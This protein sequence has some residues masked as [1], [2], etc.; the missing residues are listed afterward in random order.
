MP[1]LF[2]TIGATSLTAILLSST[3]TAYPSSHRPTFDWANTKHLITF[4][5]SYTYV[6]G[7]S[8]LQNYSFI[9]DAQHFSFTPPQL[10]ANRIVQNSTATAEGGP[11][12][13]E[14][15]TGC[16]L[17]PGLTD[18]QSCDKQLWDFAFAGADV[19]VRPETP[20]HHNYTVSFVQQVE[21]FVA[22]G[23]P[24]L[25]E[26]VF[27]DKS[28]TL[29]GIWI[30]INDIGDSSTYSLDFPAFYK[31]VTATLFDSVREIYRLGYRKFLFMQLPPLD[32]TPPNLVRA[33][34]PRPNAS[35]VD[36]WNEALADGIAGFERELEDVNVMV[37]ETTG[38]LNYVLD[39]AEEFAIRNTTGYCAGYN[40]PVVGSDPGR[41]GCEPLGEYFWFNKGHMTSH[42]HEIL[43]GKVEQFLVAQSEG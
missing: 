33:A 32:R 25:E 13:V 3:S 28:R 23:N 2:S 5:D 1:P 9:G 17:E 40:Q 24:V 41:Y 27:L 26:Y 4:G 22:Y 30:G 21:Q 29:V 20:L 14:F 39:H 35:M 43:A 34:G 36:W 31:N 11:N 38:F 18:P 15:L 37:F 19:S 12:W 42:T 6:Q 8:G 7:T 10:L 16:G